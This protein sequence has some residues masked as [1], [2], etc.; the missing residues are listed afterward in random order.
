MN[1]EF[2]KKALEIVGNP[3]VLVNIVSRR[4]RQLNAVGGSIS[5]P[6]VA[7]TA[8]MGAADVALLEIIEGKMSWI[9]PEVEDAM[10]PRKRQSRVPRSAPKVMRA[11]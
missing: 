5:R 3:N 2:V 8:N 7:D 6:L 11:A 1:A 10:R 4:V 9:M